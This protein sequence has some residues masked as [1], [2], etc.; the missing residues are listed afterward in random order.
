M[1][2]SGRSWKIS[3]KVGSSLLSYTVRNNAIGKQVN[4]LPEIQKEVYYGILWHLW[5]RIGTI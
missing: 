4:L 5:C 3:K 1:S 2:R